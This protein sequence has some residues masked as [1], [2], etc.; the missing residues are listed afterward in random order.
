MDRNKNSH[1]TQSRTDAPPGKIAHF[2]ADET[3]AVLVEYVTL[4]IGVLLM[5][6]VTITPLRMAL[7][8]FATDIYQH[9]TL[10]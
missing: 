2:F 10:P 1:S 9:L 4:L 7:I 6:Y 3:G 8:D 5:V